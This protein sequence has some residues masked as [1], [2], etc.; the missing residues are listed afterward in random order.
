MPLRFF[1][2]VRIAPGLRL[3]LSRSGVSTSV[4]GRGGWLTMGPAGIR[5]TVGGFGTGLFWTTLTPWRRLAAHPLARHEGH[6]S[7]MGWLIWLLAAYDL[8]KAVT[9]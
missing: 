7:A 2:R 3:N 5:T 9:G 4:G 6:G 8:I 1:K